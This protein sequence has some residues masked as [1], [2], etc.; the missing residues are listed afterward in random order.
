MK[1]EAHKFLPYLAPV[2]AQIALFAGTSAFAGT[3]APAAAPAPEAPYEGGRGLLTLEGPSGMF[4]NPT[5]ATLPK[6]AFTAQACYLNPNLD[7]SVNASGAMVAYGVTD[8]L[9]LGILGNYI[10][11]DDALGD[12]QSGLGPMARVRLL[13]DEGLV[14]Q[15]SVGYYAKF[16]D[17]AVETNSG[18]VAAYK[19]FPVGDESGFVKSVGVHLGARYSSLESEDV[20]VGYGG[21]EVQFPYRLYLVGE[22]S[23]KDDDVYSEIPFAAGLQWRAG[24][25]NISISAMQDG[26]FED[27]GFFFGIGTQLSF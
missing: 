21:L 1:P 17:D 7:D 12:D 6:G 3:P 18:F 9:E 8:W 14:P 15:V 16:G 4:L 23:S 13:K 22:I 10:F 25:I 20:C 27:P 5:S 19:R 24:G 11:L 26:T 2:I